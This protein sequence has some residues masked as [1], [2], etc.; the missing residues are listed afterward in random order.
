MRRCGTVL[1]LVVVLFV[2]TVGIPEA[3]V[4]VDPVGFP[5]PANCGW[6][7]QSS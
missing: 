2:A 7:S 4:F 3:D 1:V 6:C 5:T